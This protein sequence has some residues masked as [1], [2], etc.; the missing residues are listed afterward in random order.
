MEDPE[1]QVGEHCNIIRDVLVG[2][3]YIHSTDTSAQ[4]LCWFSANPVA[5]SLA[6]PC[7]HS[8]ANSDAYSLAN[9]FAHPLVSTPRLDHNAPAYATST[10]TLSAFMEEQLTKE[11][12]VGTTRDEIWLESS[13][14]YLQNPSL[15]GNQWHQ[16][17]DRGFPTVQ[18][19]H[20]QD[21]LQ[22]F[23]TENQANT[24]IVQAGEWLRESDAWNNDIS[25]V[26]LAQYQSWGI[27]VWNGNI[28]RAELGHY[29]APGGTFEHARLDPAELSQYE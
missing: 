26:Y 2:P 17:S 22:P 27:S 1:Q 5:H 15:H 14:C 6:N 3:H 29:Q 18:P 24:T 23:D 19:L 16:F 25:L 4:S 7:A 12:I 10:G 28:R 21:F 20:Q 9:P 8:L 13:E 11:T